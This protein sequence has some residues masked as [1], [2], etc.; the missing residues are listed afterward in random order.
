MTEQ[1]NNITWEA[2]SPEMGHC[3]EFQL[4]SSIPLVMNLNAKVLLMTLAL[5]VPA[6]RGDQ[7][8]GHP[9]GEFLGKDVLDLTPALSRDR[10]STFPA[11]RSNNQVCGLGDAKFHVEGTCSSGWSKQ[12]TGVKR[13]ERRLEGGQDEV[14]KDS[15]G[16]AEQPMLDA[17]GEGIP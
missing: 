12:K 7:K 2:G 14:R 3:V 8:A 10:S 15:R 11:R 4:K 16:H 17:V 9:W 13:V 6:V 1:L 5:P